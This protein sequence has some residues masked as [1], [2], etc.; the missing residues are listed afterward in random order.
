MKSENSVAAD[1]F[2]TKMA[3]AGVKQTGEAMK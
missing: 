3:S 2:R 1:F